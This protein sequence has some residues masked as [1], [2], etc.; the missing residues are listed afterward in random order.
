MKLKFA[1]TRYVRA[2]EEEC[3]IDKIQ[4]LLIEK[5]YLVKNVTN[6]SMEFTDN[7]FEFRSKSDYFIKVDK[8][9]FEIISLSSL[10]KNLRLTY[11]VSLTTPIL[12]VLIIVFFSLVI[13]VEPFCLFFILLPL[14]Q[15]IYRIFSLRST[16]NQM[17]DDILN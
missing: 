1:I 12:V 14:F 13:F 8:G 9:Y 10:Q 16:T 4:L 11:Y 6:E 17:M 5:K 7:D 3:L 2:Q 15:E